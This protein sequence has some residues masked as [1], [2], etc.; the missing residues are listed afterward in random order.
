MSVLDEAKKRPVLSGVTLVGAT[1]AILLFM[2]VMPGLELIVRIKKA[3]DIADAALDEAKQAREWINEY[4]R[5][6]KQQQELEQQRYEL[7]QEFKKKLFE[8]QSQQQMP[9]PSSQRQLP[10]RRET[11][12]VQWEQDAYGNWFC[13]SSTGDWWWPDEDTGACE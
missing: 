5:Q 6:Q 2:N 11:P 4:I 1:G 12:S 9:N 8:M 7:E 10:R 3:P 13:R